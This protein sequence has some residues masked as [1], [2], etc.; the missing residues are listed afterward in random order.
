MEL[1]LQLAKGKGLPMPISMPMQLPSLQSAALRQAAAAYSRQGATA[2]P[3]GGAGPLPDA[4]QP[5]DAAEISPQ[6]RA[7]AR[8]L[9]E[10]SQ[11]LSKTEP[12]EVATTEPA[13][14]GRRID[15]TA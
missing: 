14:D 1:P 4:R 3:V 7:R 10:T 6:A 8:E 9:A 5:V 2:Q 15:V 12:P 11:A 13:W